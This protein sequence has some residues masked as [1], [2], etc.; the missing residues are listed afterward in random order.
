[1]EEI[2]II[3]IELD[4]C[5][6]IKV[7]IYV[8]SRFEK[9]FE[10]WEIVEL[11]I[12]LKLWFSF[13]NIVGY[14]ILAVKSNIW[15]FLEVYWVKNKIYLDIRILSQLENDPI[16]LISNFQLFILIQYYA[17]EYYS[18]KSGTIFVKKKEK[19]ITIVIIIYINF[20]RGKSWNIWK[21]KLPFD[22]ALSSIYKYPWLDKKFLG[23][24]VSSY[25]G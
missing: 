7:Y 4:L 22:E 11:N 8:C 5:S 19:N 17:M 6:W 23:H 18:W 25:Y 15:K 24:C 16:I 20:Q 13:F 1:M 3:D 9:F 10:E 2:L 21:D 12:Y 14:S